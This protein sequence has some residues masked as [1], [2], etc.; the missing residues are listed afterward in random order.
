MVRVDGECLG[1]EGSAGGK[2]VELN[3]EFA[4]IKEG[5]GVFWVELDRACV[6]GDGGAWLTSTD[7]SDAE[8]IEGIG[9]VRVK[10]EGVAVGSE[11]LLPAVEAGEGVA[12]PQGDGGAGGVEA[13]C[14]FEMF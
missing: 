1:E 12:Y 4:E 10:L 11:G 13:E 9:V 7:E 2:F 5:V 14:L 6:G 3:R 8:A